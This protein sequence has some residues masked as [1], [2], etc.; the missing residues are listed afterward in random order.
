M[1]NFNKKQSGGFISNAFGIAKKLSETGLSAINH[2]APGSVSKLPQS[3]EETTVV[4]GSAQ[5]KRPF[6]QQKFDNPQQMFRSHV[7]KVT[8]QL[9]GRHFNKVNNVASFIS[10]DINDKI[11]DF[12]FDQL[13]DFVSNQ[14]SV[15]HVLK[16]V[17][18]KNLA[19]LSE[20][21]QRS[22]RIGTALANQN[23]TVAA[24]V[25]AVSGA[26][27]MLGSAIDIPLSLALTL[28]MIYQSGRAHGFELDH[29]S[30]QKVVEYVFR[31]VDFGS[32]AEKQT[33]LVAV[34]GLSSL[35]QN[36]D[37]Q[38]IQNLLGS[39]HD[40][41]L[42]KK[43]L[44]NTDG[45][46]KWTWLNKLPQLSV[47]SKLT[48]LAGAGIG[49]VYSWKLIEDA[50]LKAQ[51]IFSGAQHYLLQHPDENIDLLTAYEKSVA[52]KAEA[53]PL[54]LSP[55]ADAESSDQVE[56]KPQ[57]VVV[58]NE[59]I[60]KVEIKLKSDEPQSKAEP[61]ELGLQK[62][63]DAYVEPV[64]EKTAQ[65]SLADKGRETLPQELDG[66]ALDDSE[67]EEAAFEDSE[68]DTFDLDTDFKVDADTAQG[69][70]APNK[71]EAAKLNRAE[72]QKSAT[73][74]KSAPKEQ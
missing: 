9:L 54:L 22:D 39:S 21:P 3:P 23:K 63:V 64:E 36:K 41:E 11:S 17:G 38:Q 69:E 58:D 10:P 25:G 1:T 19:E 33:L 7:P 43:W 62:L 50:H 5:A 53:S 46:L 13:N 6:D 31:A 4:P 55:Q 37:T 51:Q 40:S 16:E 67:F 26:S 44:S 20:N 42:L 49:A 57:E 8:Q 35:L 60:K 47:L 2:V 32:I 61:V 52:L 59:V 15:D 24:V 71:T 65:V 72:E 45:T 70:V 29:K 56:F 28:K 73:K 27:G 18:A 74:K 30:E 68:K 12:F 66:S 14:S 34:R 48:P